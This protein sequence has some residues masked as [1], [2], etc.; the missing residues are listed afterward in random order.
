[1]TKT[2]YDKFLIA[3]LAAYFILFFL[4]GLFRHW[5]F[6]TTINDTGNFDQAIWG[7]LHEG[8][9]HTTNIAN[10]PV[11]RLAGHFDPILYFFVPFYALYPS[12]AWIIGAQALALS[13]AAWPIFLLGSSVFQ[14]HK[15]GFLIALVYLV[16]PFVLNAASWDFHPVTLAVPFVASAMLGIERKNLTRLFFSVFII[17]LCKEHLGIMVAGF[18]LVWLYK[19]R[20]WKIALLLVMIGMVHTYVVLEIIMPS[21]SIS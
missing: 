16:N 18:G 20:Q 19:N 14:S 7:V 2:N 13:A 3:I 21:L 17:L 4:S 12:V 1:M 5:N 10:Q 8:Y 9:L 15:T 6:L 11:N